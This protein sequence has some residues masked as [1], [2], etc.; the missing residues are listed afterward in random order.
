LGVLFASADSDLRLKVALSGM[1][2]CTAPGWDPNAKD[3]MR[4]DVNIKAG[5]ER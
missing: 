3:E 4:H 1:P 5:D 2:S